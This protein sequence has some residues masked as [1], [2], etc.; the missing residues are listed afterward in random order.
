L[1]RATFQRKLLT[2]KSLFDNRRLTKIIPALLTIALLTLPG[3]LSHS[4]VRGDTNNST[5][6]LITEYS[7][8]YI[9]TVNVAALP[10]PT[11]GTAVPLSLPDFS[12]SE[13]VQ[14]G[15][16]DPSFMVVSPGSQQFIHIVKD[17]AGTPGTNPNPCRCTPPD[18]GL[19]ASS[20]FVVQMVNLAGTI[21]KN[22][23]VKVTTFSLSDFWFLPVR[24]GPLGIGMSDPEVLYD[25]T[26]DRFYASI[27]D[28]FDVN[29]VNFA[30]TAT[31]DPTGV[32]FIYRVIANCNPATPYSNCSPASA[33]TLPDQPYIGYSTDK[34]LITANDFDTVSGAFLGAQFWVLNKA[35]MLS[36][37]TA[38]TPCPNGRNVDAKTNAVPNLMFS[39]RPAQHLSTTP[40][41]TGDTTPT[42]FMAENC[43]TVIPP[44]FL[45][46][47]CKSA[48]LGSGGM[49][50]TVIHGTPPSPTSVKTTTVPIHRISFPQR[51]D[52]PG[53]PA[54]LDTRGQ[55]RITSVVWRSNL[56]WTAFNDG[57]SATG[58]PQPACARLVQI[59]TTTLPSCPVCMANQDMDL[60]LPGASTFYPAVTTDSQ[61]NLA[62]IYGSSG[63]FKYPDLEVIGQLTT[64][65]PNTLSQATVLV[66]STA[67]DLSTR[68]GDYFWAATDPATPNT[69]WVSGEFRTTSLFQGWSTQVGEISFNT[70]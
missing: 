11:E 53:N 44:G 52:Q 47:T 17:F 45:T 21:W 51:S 26:A 24:G 59:D 13:Q 22:N 18:M 50:V 3:V 49:N 61:N 57:P 23:G 1:F 10:A 32:W 16:T 33:N 56:L 40:V 12:L 25:A 65:A 14:P 36:G 15:T 30:V 2:V 54:S 43:L 58:C 64:M 69:F 4:A 27:I 39:I 66:A 68:W 8:V 7:A 70:S 42:A 48:P 67:V 35:E 46:N 37:C 31:N 63:L 20:K 41:L 5:E 9:G 34:F 28:T 55:A 38:P 60:T 29:R 19:A 6:Q 62:V